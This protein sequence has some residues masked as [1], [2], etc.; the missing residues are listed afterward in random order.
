MNLDEMRKKATLTPEEV[1]EVLSLGR[2]STY[3]LLK[4]NL[5]PTKR[6]GAKIIIPTVPFFDWLEKRDSEIII[7]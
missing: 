2:N 3:N 4:Q 6:I 5:F 1:K 7:W